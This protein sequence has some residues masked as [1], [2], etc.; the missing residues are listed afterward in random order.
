VVWK[1]TDGK[2]GMNEIQQWLINIQG[3]I[4]R[5]SISARFLSPDF[6]QISV[7]KKQIQVNPNIMDNDLGS[8]GI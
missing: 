4:L 6:G 7:Q 1:I 2:K 8:L 3:S 5:N